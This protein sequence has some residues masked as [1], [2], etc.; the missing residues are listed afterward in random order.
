MLL[1][2]SSGHS[3][4]AVSVSGLRTTQNNRSIS[5]VT[6]SVTG[7]HPR[8]WQ[9]LQAS[10]VR[11]NYHFD[12]ALT[13]LILV[14]CQFLDPPFCLRLTFDSQPHAAAFTTAPVSSSS[15]G[16]HTIYHSTSWAVSS[17]S[18]TT[19]LLISPL[20]WL[21]ER[22]WNSSSI[23]TR[24]LTTRSSTRAKTRSKRKVRNG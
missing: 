5:W 7:S 11:I 6:R 9:F 10:L 13:L 15:V 23:L 18:T 3:C 4:C 8:C 16:Q 19:C 20:R 24:S 12:E 17:S 14:S 1:N 2:P 22:S 21:R